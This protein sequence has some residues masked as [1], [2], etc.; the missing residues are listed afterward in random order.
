MSKDTLKE[1]V[2][3]QI[4]QHRING[5]KVGLTKEL[6]IYHTGVIENI[7]LNLIEQTRKEERERIVE[8]IESLNK[9]SMKRYKDF[10]NSKEDFSND[11]AQAIAIRNQIINNIDNKSHCVDCE[12]EIKKGKA[13]CD[14]C[15][16]E[17]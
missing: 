17:L 4:K 10:L 7:I 12:T 14:V 2:F 3:D 8:M 9:K 11:E 6:E 13:Q 5:D 16:R 15:R 1:R